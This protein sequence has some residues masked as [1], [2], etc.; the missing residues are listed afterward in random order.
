ML[1]GGSDALLAVAGAE[2]MVMVVAAVLVVVV[3]RFCFG[4]RCPRLC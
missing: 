4:R 1:V 3:A 2:T